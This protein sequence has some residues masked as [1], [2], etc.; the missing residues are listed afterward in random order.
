MLYLFTGNNR[1]LIQ[2]EAQKWKKAFWEK[3]GVENVVYITNLE[4]ISEDFLLENMLSQSLFSPKRL[5]LI[6]G[7]PFSGERAF[8][9]ASELE[10][11]ILE[12]IEKIPEDILVVFL[13]E[14]PDKRKTA[15]KKLSKLAEVKLYNRR[16]WSHTNSFTKIQRSNRILSA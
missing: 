1:Y 4:N 14:N 2:Q 3:Y 8:S 13:S 9:W 10:K 7:F 11:T 12:N 15:Y 6:D 5:V 16:R